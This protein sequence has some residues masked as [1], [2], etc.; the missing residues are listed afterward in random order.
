[1]KRLTQIITRP[2]PV[3]LVLLLLAAVVYHGSLDNG[4]HYDDEHSIVRNPGIRAL[5]NLPAF[6]TDPALFSEDPGKAMYRPVFLCTLAL[7]HAL[8]GYQVA[9]YH[10]VN[11]AIHVLAAWMVYWLGCLLHSRQGGAL[12]A[13]LFLV[14]PLATEPVNYISS[15]S[16]SLAVLF[17]LAGLNLHLRQRRVLGLAAYAL[18]L[19]TKSTAIVLPLLLL[20]WE[21]GSVQTPTGRWRRIGMRVAPYL[22]VSLGYLLLVQQF[23]RQAYGAQQVRSL[24]VQLLTQL[25]ALVYY[26]KLLVLPHPLSVEHA[27]QESHAVG[28]V[29][30]AAFAVLLSLAWLAVVRRPRWPALALA[31]V[32]LPLL[33]VALVPLNVLVN[34]HRLYGSIA[35]GMGGLGAVL[36]SARGLGRRV[37]AGVLAGLFA[38]WSWQSAARTRD[39]QDE[40]GLWRQALEVAPGMPRVHFLLGEAYRRQGDAP[41]AEQAYLEADRLFGGS[42]EVQLN[43]GAL[44][45]E[46][47]ERTR[48]RAVLESLLRTQPDH[49]QVLYNLALVLEADEPDRALPLLQRAWDLR[50]RW[51]ECGLALGSLYESTGDVGRARRL[52]E[53]LTI[54]FPRS[55]NTWSNLGQVCARAQE[56][57]RAMLA[58]ETALQLEPDHPQARANLELLQQRVR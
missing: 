2:V 32:V 41:A 10:I 15:R 11:L 16:E 23:L 26:L 35:F 12:G 20:V 47:G 52:L 27:F 31:A 50:P 43:L 29:H 51:L 8:G 5:A 28:W 37:Q 7:N 14:H 39:W 49:P 30:V 58:W 48:A 13:L 42:V 22:V 18:G 54:R 19:L 3:L 53:D 36:V 4:F 45:L 24:P 56:F 9:G 34:E 33:P 46:R 1:M 55:A 40:L 17:C 6:F 57:D 25:K 44:Y 21:L 38:V